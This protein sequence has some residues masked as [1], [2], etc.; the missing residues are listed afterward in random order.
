MSGLSI[1]RGCFNCE[2]YPTCRGSLDEEKGINPR[3]I[4]EGRN[5]RPYRCGCCCE[6]YKPEKVKV[7]FT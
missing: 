7:E 4:H 3:E 6:S 1:N 2:R 5:G